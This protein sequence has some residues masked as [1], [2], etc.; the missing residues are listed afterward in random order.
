MGARVSKMEGKQGCKLP[1]EHNSEE[2]VRDGSPIRSH[3]YSALPVRDENDRKGLLYMS[4]VLAR[5]VKLLSEHVLH[6][7]A[8]G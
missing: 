5:K 8:Q 4:S 6:A 7:T 3:A 1:S 2:K